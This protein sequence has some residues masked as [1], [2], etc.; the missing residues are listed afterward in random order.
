MSL[1]DQS[2][3][4]ESLSCDELE[5]FLLNNHGIKSKFCKILKGKIT[6]TIPNYSYGTLTDYRY[7]A[8]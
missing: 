2:S 1:P 5:Q 7:L 8:S 6:I 3:K 4:I